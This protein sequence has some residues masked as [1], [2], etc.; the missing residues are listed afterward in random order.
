MTEQLLKVKSINLTPNEEHF[1]NNHILSNPSCKKIK[2]ELNLIKINSFDSKTRMVLRNIINKNSATNLVLL[3]SNPEHSLLAWKINALYFIKLPL[4]SRDI[5]QCL[6]RLM[7][8]EN[9]RKDLE[10]LKINYSGGTELI[11]PS[12]INII[13]GKGNYCDFYTTQQRNKLTFSTRIQ[14]VGQMLNHIPYLVRLNTSTIV[15][16]NNIVKLEKDFAYFK[17]KQAAAVKISRRV[18]YKLREELFWINI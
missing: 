2:S 6:N 8:L 9:T 16:V 13:S 12:E 14:K 5:Y 10:T 18:N 17:G 15:N 3:S 1:F 4:N 11:H 7:I